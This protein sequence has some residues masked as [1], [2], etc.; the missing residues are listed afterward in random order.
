VSHPQQQTGSRLHAF[1]SDHF[2]FAAIDLCS[3]AILL[4]PPRIIGALIRP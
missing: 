2:F 3:L 4:S 1:L